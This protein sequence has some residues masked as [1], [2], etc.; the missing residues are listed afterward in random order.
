MNAIRESGHW[1]RRS[2]AAGAILLVLLLSAPA[3]LSGQGGSKLSREVQDK[4]RAA[5]ADDLLRVIIQTTGE[6]T[7]AHFARL[8]GRGG[9]GKVR[10]QAIRGDSASVAAFHPQAAPGG[11]GGAP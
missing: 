5:G 9:A 1:L 11:P 10:H 6:P 8:H 3:A 2:L 7:S 4:I